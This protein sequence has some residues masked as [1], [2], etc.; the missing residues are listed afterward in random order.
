MKSYKQAIAAVAKE[1]THEVHDSMFPTFPFQKAEM[2]AFIFD[3]DVE[4]VVKQI[5][6][7]EIECRNDWWK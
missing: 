2:I 4:K 6:T 3:V 1:Y 7:A 5:K